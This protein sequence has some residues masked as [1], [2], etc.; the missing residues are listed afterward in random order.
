MYLSGTD[1]Y[2][3]DDEV[4]EEGE[5]EDDEEESDESETDDD[6]GEDEK[7]EEEGEDGE[8]EE[9]S[10][11][12]DDSDSDG[13]EESDKCPICLLGFR[14]NDV[15]VPESCDHTFCLDCIQEW[16][17]VITEKCFNTAIQEDFHNYDYLEKSVTFGLCQNIK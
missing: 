17:K 14:E 8:K 10:S 9:V 11:E 12:E 1:D 13:K 16:A 2:D 4:E 3:D 15:G 5:E 6:E 7:S